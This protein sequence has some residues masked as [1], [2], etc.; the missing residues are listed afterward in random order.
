MVVLVLALCSLTQPASAA[1]VNEKPAQKTEADTLNL[2]L[3]N[4]MDI[5][6]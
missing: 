3:S 6:R 1:D 2:K 5:S 4:S